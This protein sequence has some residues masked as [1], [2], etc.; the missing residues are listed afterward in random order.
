MDEDAGKAAACRQ[1][2][3]KF[4]EE[5][6]IRWVPAFCEMVIQEAELP[7]YQAVAALTRSFIEFEM[8]EMNRNGDGVA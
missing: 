1:I 4:I 7:F 2:E 5:H 8:E 3:K 6:L